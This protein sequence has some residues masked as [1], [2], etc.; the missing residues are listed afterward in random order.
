MISERDA[1]D[2]VANDEG[3]DAR[4]QPTRDGVLVR[5]APAGPL[6]TETGRR[7][8]PTYQLKAGNAY[9]TRFQQRPDI[10]PGD[11][12]VRSSC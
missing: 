1:G 10:S 8:T 4:R 5:P 7:G 11:R 3:A 2:G 6:M 9:L 12:D